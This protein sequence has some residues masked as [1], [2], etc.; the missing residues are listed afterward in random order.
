MRR[1]RGIRVLWVSIWIAVLA[2]GATGLWVEVQGARFA[3][4]VRREARELWSARRELAPE[5]RSLDGL[6]GPVVRYLDLSGAARREPVRSVRLRHG[7]TFRPAFDK[8][9]LPIRG[10]QYFGA[11]PPGFV[12]WGRIRLAPGLWLEARDT[13]LGG[14]GGMLVEV[15]S[16]WTLADA[17]GPELDQGALVRLL[18]EMA[19]FPTAFLDG[20]HVAWAPIDQAS[21]RATLRVGGREVAATFHFGPDGLP[22]GVAADRYRDVGGKGVLTPFLGEYRDYREVG[23]LLIPFRCEVSWQV[24]GR[25]QPYARWELE[26]VELDVPEPY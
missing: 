12:W 2:V 25:A 24:D 4:R 26:Q 15:A 22:S 5:R 14:Q 7:G 18:A 16:V 19:W 1:A 6:P 11:R 3:G 8:P 17:R 13:S 20:R 21:A 10:E 23:G 9:W